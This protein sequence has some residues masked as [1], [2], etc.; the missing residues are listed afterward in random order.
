MVRS[1]NLEL[2]QPSPQH[3]V[4]PYNLLPS[5]SLFSSQQWYKTVQHLQTS[6]NS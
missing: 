5:S 2:Q 3:R 6:L 4:H 1:P